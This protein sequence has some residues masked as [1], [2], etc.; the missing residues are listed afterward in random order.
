VVVF[1]RFMPGLLLAIATA[2]APGVYAQYGEPPV[3]NPYT[4]RM[5]VRPR[6]FA[7]V[8]ATQGDVN[9]RRSH[10]GEFVPARPNIPL[11]VRDQLQTSA[12]S[13]AEIEFDPTNLVRLAPNTDVE[14]SGLDYRRYR[15]Q[16]TTGTILYRL[17]RDFGAQAII[18]MPFGLRAAPQVK[19]EYRISIVD[20]TIRVT[21]RSGRLEVFSP[22]LRRTRL[23]S[24]GQTWLITG[25]GNN[26]EFRPT[27]EAARDH[28]DEWSAYRD[29]QLARIE[30]YYGD[31][32][33]K[34]FGDPGGQNP[35]AQSFREGEEHSGWHSFGQAEH[36]PGGSQR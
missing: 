18:Q 34:R 5:P 11:A 22:S 32:G 31:G 28:F 15:F 17:S 26:P 9:V 14:I 21:V 16:F 4:A 10:S 13:R 3:P 8:S 33:W 35:N 30:E 27:F 29:H 25:E 2:I 24:P 20:G 6:E 1:K 12:G 36:S 23:L 19:G 7:R